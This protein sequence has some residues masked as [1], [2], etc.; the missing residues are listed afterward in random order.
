MKT[1][2]LKNRFTLLLMLSCFTLLRADTNI[3]IYVAYGNPYKLMVEGRVLDK[4]VHQEATK[5]DN[6]LQNSWNKLKYL[7]NDEVKNEPIT[8]MVNG[9]KAQSKT[10]DEGYFEFEL[11][12][13][14]STWKNHQPITVKLNKRNIIKKGEALI[15]NSHTTQG[16]ISDFD[17][18]LIVSD[19]TNKLKLANNTFF[20][21]YKQRTL[22]KGM[23]ERFETLKSPL[24]IVTGSPKQLQPTIEKFLDYHHFPKRIIITK[25]AHGTNSDPLFDQLAYKVSKIEKLIE[26]FPTIVWDCFGDS[27]EKDKEVYLALA[28]K[29]PNHI[30]NIYIRNVESGKIDKI[31]F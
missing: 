16:I 3:E 19:V 7:V 18:T 25:K 24:F 6:W 2:L 26:L 8:L 28:Q 29:Y 30:G 17:D 15:L 13:T 22:V 12:N 31:K 9:I 23:R 21:N 20:K 14:N 4:R 10:D 5:K 11:F 27:G 1:T